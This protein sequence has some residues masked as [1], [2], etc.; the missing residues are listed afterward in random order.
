MEDNSKPP[1]RRP[2]A[3]A[4]I[5]ENFSTP[6]SVQT[7]AKLASAGGGPFYRYSGRFPVYDV[8]DLLAWG[9]AKVGPRVSS[10]TEAREMKASA[11]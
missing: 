7:L 5:R 8:A 6:C 4:F 9:T 2:A 10:V 3:A 1:L 11:A